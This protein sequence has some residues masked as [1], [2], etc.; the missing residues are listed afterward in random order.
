MIHRA[1]RQAGFSL[2]EL[3]VVIVIIATLIGLM[4]PAVQ[5]AREAARRAQCANNLKQIGIAL[6]AYEALHQCYPF[7]WPHLHGRLPT[8]PTLCDHREGPQ[9]LSILFRL[10]PQLDMLPLYSAT[11]VVFEHCA[12]PFSPYPHPANTTSLAVQV[13]TFLCPSDGHV[14]HGAHP[15][16]YR[17]NVGVGPNWGQ[18]AECP[19]SGNGFFPWEGPGR[20]A[21]IIDGLAHTAAFSERLLGSGQFERK[22]PERDFGDLATWC[23]TTTAD[24]AL[25]GCRLAS[26]SL[27]FPFVTNGGHRWFVSQRDQTLYTHAQ[28]PNGSIPDGIDMARPHKGLVAARSFHPGGVNVL[29]G[30]GSTRFMSETV[31][32]AVWRALGTRDG[33]EVVE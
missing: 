17:G 5:A 6:N 25:Q 14:P 9:V 28:E 10:T 26:A 7:Q 23:D 19:D 33:R 18:S 1:R 29:M 32:R 21:L 22:V 24:V 11:N 2:V 4:L 31:Q 30:D 15:S 8:P 16:A 3:L 13:A 12:A 27:D 20:T